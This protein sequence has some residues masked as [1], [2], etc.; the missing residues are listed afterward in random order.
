MLLARED[1]AGLLRKWTRRHGAV[2]NLLSAAGAR[3]EPWEDKVVHLPVFL[4]L[5]T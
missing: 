1:A 5:A 4:D 2:E 3:A